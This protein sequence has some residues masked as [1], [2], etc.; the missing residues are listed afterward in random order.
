MSLV[1]GALLALLA[2]SST[3]GAGL[4]L[5]LSHMRARELWRPLAAALLANLLVVP[6]A[7]LWLL[8]S[9]SL[10]ASSFA[11]LALVA[12]A[13]GGAS[14]PLL[15]RLAGGE[16]TRVGVVYISLC[17][18][19][20]ATLGVLAPLVLPT[21]GGGLR[22]LLI[23]LVLQLLPLL[24]GLMVRSRRAALAERWAAGLR[25]AGS[26]LLALVVIV[27]LITRGSFLFTMGIT[28]LV[29]TLVLVLVTLLAGALTV[30]PRL[31]DALLAC[32]RNLTLALMIAEAQ[33]PGGAATLVVAAYGL[34]MYV[35]ASLCLLAH[36]RVRRGAQEY[37]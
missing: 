3:I 31:P 18:G 29:S 13:P 26:L 12:L 1:V 2:L 16:P 34:V 7:S 10:P 23:M 24:L 36:K 9:V 35:V 5:E 32:V 28:T 21:Q 8:R 6:L 17:T 20:L 27:L 30:S 25:R 11:G 33:E 14:A 37:P 15:A 22:V 19:C 4:E